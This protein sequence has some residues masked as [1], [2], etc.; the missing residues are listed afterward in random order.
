MHYHALA[1]ALLGDRKAIEKARKG[2]ACWADAY[3]AFAERSRRDTEPLFRAE[4]RPRLSTPEY[5]AET[6]ERAGIRVILAD[7]PAFPPGLREIPHP[8]H[9]LYVKG[10]AEA[11]GAGG[12]GEIRMMAIVGT[13]R[14]TP[15]GKMLARRFGRTLSA[16]GF[17]IASG[18]AFGIDAAGHEGCLEGRSGSAVAVLAGGLEGIY[19]KGNRSLAERIIKEGGALVA[20]Y[21]PG[22]TPLPRRFIER[23]RIISGLSRGIVVVE[24]PEGSGALSTA[25]FAFEQNRDLFVL[26]GSAL[27]EH[28]RGSNSLIKQGAALVTSPEDILE[29][30]GMVIKKADGTRDGYAEWKR[31][32]GTLTGEESDVLDAVAHECAAHG[33]AAD[34]DK[35][36]AAAKLEPRIVNRTLTFLIMKGLIREESG[37]FSLNDHR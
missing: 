27:H 1:T 33:T 12:R 6:A 5:L 9:A 15:E 16:H 13:R 29:S 3:A 25:R 23:N 26:P 8:P 34:I 14:A 7:D 22:E 37:G 36:S 18:L 32:T 20:E 2:Y 28:Y 35:I 21:P 24:A 19:P 4:T 11:L 17:A 30:Y 10:N 31:R